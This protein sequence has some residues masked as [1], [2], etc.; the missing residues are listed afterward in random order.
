[1]TPK[2]N[3][4]GNLTYRAAHLHKPTTLEEIQ[5]IVR[6]SEKVRVLGSRHS[7]NTIADTPGTHISLEALENIVTI[8]REHHTATINAG[9]K[10]GQLCEILDRAEYALPNLASLPHI[11]VAGAC[12]TATHGSGVEN[13]NLATVVS[14]MELVTGMGEIVHVSRKDEAFNGMVVGLGALGVVTKITLELQSA[15][16]VRQYV[17]ENLPLNELSN[18]FDDIL[19]NSYSVS[20]F[21]DWSRDVINQVWLKQRLTENT[22]GIGGPEWHGATLAPV[23]RHPIVHL[24]AE[25]CTEQMGIPGPW[26]ERLP[27]FRM[28]FTPSSGEELQSEYFVAHKDAFAAFQAIGQIRDQISPLILISEVRTI[29]ADNLWMS[30]CYQQDSVAFHFTWKMD[31]PGVRELLPKLEAQLAP[32]NARPHWGKLFTMSPERLQSLYKKLSDF[33]QLLATYDPQGKF[34]NTFL[35]MNIY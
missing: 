19:S 22:P 18:H 25:P 29:A 3:W 31:W 11:S 33:R 28:A 26:Y 21:T 14:A 16:S 24:S 34:R 35:E 23:R 2:Q 1:M 32:F 7:F 4:A 10:Y 9:M 27:H 12:A 20:L 6:Q 13:G 17:Y 8:D 15:F 5:E 30:P